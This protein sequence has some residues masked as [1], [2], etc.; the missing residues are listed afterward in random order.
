MQSKEF[1]WSKYKPMDGIL[2]I[3]PVWITERE[4]Q[5]LMRL[6]EKKPHFCMLL[7][8]VNYLHLRTRAKYSQFLN[9][10]P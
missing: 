10:C 8:T 2:V 4:I 3:Q 6:L 5:F 1:P 9:Y 7:Y